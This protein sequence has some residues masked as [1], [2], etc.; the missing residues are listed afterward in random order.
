M[1]MH[2]ETRGTGP[3]LV[4]LHGW[5]LDSRVWSGVA[6]ELARDFR[7]TLIDLPGHG[8]SPARA[9]TDLPRM[10][11]ALLRAAPGHAV[12]LGWSL[13]GLAALQ[14]ALDEPSRVARV[15]TVAGTP[16]FVQAGD[17]PRAVAP[18]V[19]DGFASDLQGDYPGTVR[20]FLALQ[21][22]GSDQGRDTLRALRGLAPEEGTAA[23]PAL[24]QGLGILRQAD[25]RPRLA[26][27]EVPLAMLF[28]ARDGLV[29]AG[30]AEHIAGLRPDADIT[31]LE[32]AGHAPFISHPAEF[33]RWVRSVCGVD[34]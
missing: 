25:L 27:L 34:G 5:G 32:G 20:R 10:A 21:A 15:L 24:A 12:W 19:F 17:W 29:P 8:R 16:R 28:G 2:C 6:D 3:D 9:A 4:L 11:R 31:I 30:V 7:L 18:A 23:P 14:A 26:A 13:G 33:C 1:A 22:R